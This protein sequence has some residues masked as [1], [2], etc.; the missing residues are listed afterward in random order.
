MLIRLDNQG[1][2][3]I[4]EDGEAVYQATPAEFLADAPGLALSIPAGMAMVTFETQSGVAIGYD[5]KGNAFPGIEW[6]NTTDLL[7]CAAALKQAHAARQGAEEAP[8][9]RFV[10]P[11]EVVSDTEDVTA[12]TEVTIL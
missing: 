1:A 12:K 2:V 9:E 8:P 10:R 7:L 11:Q 6:D 5:A 4:I 3:S